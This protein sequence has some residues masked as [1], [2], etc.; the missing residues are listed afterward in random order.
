MAAALEAVVVVLGALA[1]DLALGDP[2]NRVH[3]VAWIGRLIAWGRRRLARGSPSRLL[4]A[5]TALTVGA[6]LL[7]LVTGAA[8]S[9]VAHASGVAGLALECLALKML[10][11]ARGLA[12]AAAAVAA[13]LER[14]DLARARETVGVHLVS[15][16]TRDLDEPHVA[17]AVIESVAENLTDS[18]LG[19]VCFFLVFGLPGAALYRA[20]NTAD[21]MLGYRE[22]DLEHFGKAAA[23]LDDVLNLLPAR[24]AGLGIVAGALLVGGETR[25]AWS[26]M[27]RDHGLTASPNAGWTMAA[28]AG[29]L[30]V[31]LE[32]FGA[33]RLGDGPLPRR[34]D[35]PRSLRVL[36]AATISGAGA[37]VGL[38]LLAAAIVR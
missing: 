5:G 37:L 22:G 35:V 20:V 32:K 3:P 25:R 7:A 30:A 15:R 17:S 6:S 16:P 21:A 9:A 8:I 26:M 18:V 28:M 2:P 4:I 34:S 19:P 38:R 1:L 29:A 13:D 11:S 24:F 12:R 31:S 33:Y 14:G 10:L 36:G 23:R 27:R